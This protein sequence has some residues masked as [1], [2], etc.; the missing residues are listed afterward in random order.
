VDAFSNAYE[1]LL[2]SINTRQHTIDLGA[3]GVQTA[4][5]QEFDEMFTEQEVWDTIKGMPAD[6]PPGQMGSVLHSTSVLGR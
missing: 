5:L 2:G 1:E 6:R 3:V 4:N